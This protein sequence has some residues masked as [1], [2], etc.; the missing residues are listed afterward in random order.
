MDGWVSSRFPNRLIDQHLLIRSTS[1][2][3]FFQRY[4]IFSA[5]SL[6]ASLP[7]RKKNIWLFGI[8]ESLKRIW[9]FG[10]H[11]F[12]FWRKRAAA[13]I[14]RKDYKFFLFFLSL[15]TVMGGG[16]LSGRLSFVF[17]G[18]SNLSSIYW[19]Y[20]YIPPFITDRRIRGANQREPR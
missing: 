17:Q 19:L 18:G 8:S 20:I 1:L 15:S 16:G 14:T 11:V 2:F 6:F 13:L 5:L 10:A 12:I 9:F 4:H 3:H 7:T